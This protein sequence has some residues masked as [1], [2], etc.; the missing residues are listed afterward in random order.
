MPETAVNIAA[1]AVWALAVTNRLFAFN[2]VAHRSFLARISS[3]R[4]NSRLAASISRWFSSLRCQRGLSVTTR[5]FV[6]LAR[7]DDQK[8]IAAFAILSQA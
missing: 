4:S 3:A 5:P 6:Q 2:D 8:R 1:S 7:W